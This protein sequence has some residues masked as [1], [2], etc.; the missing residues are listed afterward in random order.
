MFGYLLLIFLSSSENPPI[1]IAF[2]WH[3][4]QPVYAPYQGAYETVIYNGFPGGPTFSFSLFDVWEE[5]G[6]P[7][8]GWAVDAIETGMNAGLQ[9][10]GA[11]LTLSGSL[12]EGLNDLQFHNWNFG[13]YSG[14]KNRFIQGLSYSTSLGNRRLDILNFPYHHP[15]IGLIWEEDIELQIAIYREFFVENFGVQ[16]S[17]GLFPPEAAFSIRA[18]P[19]LLSQ[20]IDWVIVDNIHLSRTLLDYPWNGGT[21]VVE[22][23]PADMRNGY[24][25]LHPSSGWV[26]L[27]NVW[28]PEPVAAGWGYRPHYAEY[29]E[30]ETGERKRI[31]LIPAA[32]YMGNE[33][34][35][36][37]FGALDYETVLSQLEPYNTDQEHPILVVLHH[38]GDNYGGGSDSYYHQNFENFVNW[39]LSN[40]DRFVPTTIE[41]YLELFPPDTGDIVYI[42]DGGWIGSGTLDPEFKKWLGDPDGSGYSPDWNSYAVITAAHNWVWTANS[43]LPYSS[44]SDILHGTGNAT[45]RAFHYFLCAETSDYEYWEGS[46]DESIWNSNP[47]RACNLALDE[48]MNLVSSGN[49]EVGPSIFVPQREPYNP[50]GTEFGFPK[51]SDFEVWTFIYDL[52]GISSAH[53]H[54]R[55]DDDGKVDY[56][57]Q[58]LNWGE[59]DS[60]PMNWETWN[61]QTDPQPYFKA[62]RYFATITGISEKV[63]DYYVSATD[64]LG[65][66]NRSPIMHV[67]VGSHSQGSNVG[68]FPENP[69][70]DDTITIYVQ[71]NMGGWLH[72]GINGWNTPDTLYWPPGTFL[73]WDSVAVETP[74]IG[75]DSMGRYYVEIGPFNIPGLPVEIID[76]VI[77]F[78][79]GSWDNNNGNDYHIPIESQGAFIMDGV[80]DEEAQLIASYNGYYLWA[81]F[82]GRELYVATNSAGI[83][84]N[85]Y[86]HFIFITDSL[87]GLINAPWAKSGY[88]TMWDAYLG[89]ENDNGWSGWFDVQNPDGAFSFASSSESGVLEGVINLEDEYGTIP[90]GIYLAACGYETQD[91]GELIWQVPE[92]VLNPGTV[93]PSE[94]VYFEL[95]TWICGDINGDGAV[96]MADLSYLANYLFFGGPSPPNI[97]SADVNGDGSI[98]PADLSYLMNYL[99]W[100]GPSPQCL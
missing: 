5:R 10:L 16:P 23:N 21:G 73:Y 40:P 92:G 54:Y 80:L 52:S 69:S 90:Q 94:F 37:G 77:H 36:G 45:A 33:D 47:T 51:S 29:V 49:D 59:W 88:V 50:G 63:V 48:I 12:I 6:G 61:S 56:E 75:P 1:Y 84:G 74:L 42:E 93:D 32:C 9:H 58:I 2:L 57:N 35:R 91:G 98:T 87:D 83:G 22:P 46:Q 89:N 86:D 17:N 26:Y 41:D 60:I 72:W 28:A 34:G 97:T 95:S 70:E 76:F 8:R 13:F 15:I 31:L 30:P 85:P 67:Y 25:S 24:L 20:N 66:Y 3:N 55:I 65:N 62:R 19:P 39:V 38:D 82:N 99:V 7:Y 64:S 27:Y 14:W 100:G 4:H 78:L 43:L 44:I 81:A 11:Q 79:D 96:N 18:I 68:W 71:S 53:L